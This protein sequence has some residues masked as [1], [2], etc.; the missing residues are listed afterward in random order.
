MTCVLG[1]LSSPLRGRQGTPETTTHPISQILGT[2]S[3]LHFRVYI[4]TSESS[5]PPIHTL[6]DEHF[7]PPGV[8]CKLPS[9]RRGG[10]EILIIGR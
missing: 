8:S 4:G 5:H 9:E 1:A 2:V 10:L 7:T 3:F 6:A